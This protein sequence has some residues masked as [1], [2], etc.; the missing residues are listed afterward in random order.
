M[1][2]TI[3]IRACV[4]GCI[5]AFVLPMVA[6]S[7]PYVIAMNGNRVDVERIQ[8]RPNGDLVITVGG[9]PQDIPRNQY[10]RAVGVQPEGMDQARALIGEQ[11]GAEAKPILTEI[12]NSS[13]FQSWDAMAG[14]LLATIHLNEGNT[15]QAQQILV[16]LRQRYGSDLESFFPS[17]ELVDWKTKVAAGET[18]GL[19]EE[20][21]AIIKEGENRER[22]GNAHLVR[23]DLKVRHR[24]QEAAVL[25]Y[26][27]TVYFYSD[28]PDIQAEALFKTAKTFAEIGD[29]SRLRKYSDLLKERY[30]DSEFASREIGL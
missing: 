27:R 21:N 22:K 18:A 3:Q 12:M 6:W 7:Q 1:K 9:Q 5:C 29:T 13:R 4:L 26:L 30:P 25:D 11:K 24:N 28:F 19:E 8:V 15:N 14:D 23:G 2:D 17:I 10:K 20:L 16:T